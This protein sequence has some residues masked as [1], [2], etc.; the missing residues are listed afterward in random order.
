MRELADSRHLD[1]RLVAAGD[2]ALEQGALR[3]PLPDPNARPR[4]AQLLRPEGAL[5]EGKERADD[6]EV[7]RPGPE[8][9]QHAQ[10]LGRLVVLGKRALQGQ[11]R[12]LGQRPHVAGS[13]PRHQ[14]VGQAMGLLVGPGDDDDRPRR[15]KAR[16]PDGKVRRAGGGGHTKDARLRQM[17]P[18]GVDERCDAAI[19][20]ARRGHAAGMV[21]GR[22]G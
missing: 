13:D 4:G 2:E 3:D 19:T 15:R 21:P 17:G 11:G 8:V 10:P 1:T 18:K 20:A 7:S 16:A 12:A 6:D 5:D 14:V 22:L 9:G